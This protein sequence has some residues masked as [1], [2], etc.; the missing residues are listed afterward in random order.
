MGIS[1]SHTGKSVRI[2]PVPNFYLAALFVVVPF[3]SWCH[4]WVRR[5]GEKVYIKTLALFHSSFPTVAYFQSGFP[6]VKKCA[7]TLLCHILGDVAKKR[8]KTLR[9]G[10]KCDGSLFSSMCCSAPG[11]RELPFFA[12]E[13]P[14]F[15]YFNQILFFPSSSPLFWL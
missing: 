6:T 10:C 13:N 14:Y 5:G 11:A 2:V 7:V 15:H 3:V 4:F 12:V 8:E 1:L 9:I